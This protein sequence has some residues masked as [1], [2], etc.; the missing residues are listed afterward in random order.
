[1][2]IVGI[3]AIFSVINILCYGRRSKWN[4]IILNIATKQT[5]NAMV[6]HMYSELIIGLRPVSERRLYFVTTSLIGWV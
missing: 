4:I 3:R 5:P 6:M 2:Q 1:M